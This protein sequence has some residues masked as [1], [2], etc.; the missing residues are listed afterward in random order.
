MRGIVENLVFEDGGAKSYAFCGVL[1]ELEGRGMLQN[2]R[3]YAGSG[4]GALFATLLAA[5][6]TIVEI[7]G[8]LDQIRFPSFRNCFEGIRLIR[9][10]GMNTSKGLEKKIRQI[11]SIRTDPDLTLE[12]LFNRTGKDLVIVACNLNT[13][14]PVYFHHWRYRSVKIIDALMMS[15]TLPLIMK[16]VKVS[17]QYYVSGAVA[18]AFPIHVFDDLSRL[19]D[20]YNLDIPPGRLS[21]NTMGIKLLCSSGGAREKPVRPITGIRSYVKAIIRALV[22]QVERYGRVYTYPGQVIYVT[23]N[24]GTYFSEGQR[25]QL[26]RAGQTAV[27]NF[28]LSS[29]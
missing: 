18:D 5:N 8:I 6:F 10:Y 17:G 1:R 25:D 13:N 4:S 27:R 19:Y 28:A 12:E 21:A 29:V 9:S 3:R 14:E 26:Y 20:G 2:T 7:G 15:L 16:P 23:T 11:L 22:S 24:H